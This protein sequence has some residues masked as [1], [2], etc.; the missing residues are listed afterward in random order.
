FGRDFHE[1][2]PLPDL[3]RLKWPGSGDTP[4]VA[5]QENVAP[6]Q[7][8]AKD[9]C[10][11]EEESLPN[12]EDVPAGEPWIVQHEDREWVGCRNDTGTRLPWLVI[13]RDAHDFSYCY[14]SDITLISRL[15][16]EHKEN[17]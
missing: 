5:E 4:T 17:A 14:D 15:V 2:T 8:V 11:N 12:P 9:I 1:V 3:P 13:N 7:V 10:N 6:D 16:P